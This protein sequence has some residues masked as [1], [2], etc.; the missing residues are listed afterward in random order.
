MV[1][2]GQQKKRAVSAADKAAEAELERQS[3]RGEYEPPARELC[4]FRE[5][6]TPIDESGK[7]VVETRT[8]RLG[9]RLTE[10]VISLKVL[11][12]GVWAEVAYIDC[13]HG[14]VHLHRVEGQ[15]P[16]TLGRLDRIEDVK[17]AFPEASAKIDALGVTVRD[18]RKDDDE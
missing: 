7:V 3:E 12:L 18:Q 1:R 9:S 11:S 2:R 16:S 17:L 10:F 13:K 15:E 5:W 14:H 8:W 4:H 6:S